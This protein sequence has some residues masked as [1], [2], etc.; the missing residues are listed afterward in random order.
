LLALLEVAIGSCE[1]EV[2]VAKVEQM[3]SIWSVGNHSPIADEAKCIRWNSRPAIV[4]ENTLLCAATRLLE[5]R[6][7]MQLTEDE[8]DALAQTVIQDTGQYIQWRTDDELKPE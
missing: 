2:A 5:V 8:W 3:G 6:A 1:P 7:N 4:M